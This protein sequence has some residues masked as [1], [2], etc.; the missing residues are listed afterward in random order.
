[1][2]QLLALLKEAGITLDSSRC[3]CM[4]VRVPVCVR[5]FIQ[6]WLCVRGSMEAC[7]GFFSCDNTHTHTHI[8]IYIYIYLHLIAFSLGIQGP[9]CSLGRQPT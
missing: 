3:A 7:C 4:R 6:G 2:Q 8:Y 5:V 9:H 1:M